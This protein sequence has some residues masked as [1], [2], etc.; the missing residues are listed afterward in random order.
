MEGQRKT[1]HLQSGDEGNKMCNLRMC[2]C[3][4]PQENSRKALVCVWVGWGEAVV[5]ENGKGLYL[6][7]DTQPDFS[8]LLW[9]A[10]SCANCELKGAWLVISH[11][12]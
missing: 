2:N 6:G 10:I 5:F 9:S 3:V 12:A 4:Q 7:L 11:S 1:L 8:I